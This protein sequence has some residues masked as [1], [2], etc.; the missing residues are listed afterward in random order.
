MKEIENQKCLHINRLNSRST[1]IPA[2]KESVYYYNKQESKNI[3]MLNG[4]YDFTYDGTPSGKIDVPSM[5]QYKGFGKHRYTNVYYPFPLMPPYVGNYN[6]IGEYERTFVIDDITKKYILHFDGVDNAFYVY[7]NDKMAGFSKG[8]HCAS[9]FDVTDL[10]LRGENTLKVVVYTFSDASYLEC[11][12]MIWANG[13]FRDVYLICTEEISIW[14]YRIIR[15]CEDVSVKVEVLGDDISSSEIRVRIDGQE[16]VRKANDENEFLFK[17]NNAQL[18]NAEEPNLYDLTIELLVN[19]EVTEIHSKKIGLCE[20]AI[21][22]KNGMFLVN[23]TPVRFK[24]VNRHEYTPDNGRAVTYEQTKRELQLLKNN[25]FNAIR[26]SHYINNPYFYELCSELG[27]YVIDEADLESHGMWILGDQG[28]LSK[29]PE[30]L[31]AYFDRNERMY[32]RNKN[33]TCIMVWSIGNESGNGP[34]IE[35][36]IEYLRKCEVKK[37]VLY[38]QEGDKIPNLIDFC[39]C[40]YVPMWAVE[41]MNYWQR[42]GKEWKGKGFPVQF[43]EYAHCM[44]NSP[45]ILYNYWKYIYEHPTFNGGFIWEFKNHGIKIGDSYYYGGD[46]DDEPHAL[47]FCMDGLLLSDSTPK[48]G[49]YEAAEAMSPVWVDKDDDGIYIINTNDFKDLSYL[50][51][52]WEIQ[53]DYDI[54]QKGELKIDLKPRNRFNFEVP[55]YPQKAGCRYYLNVNSYDGDKKIGSKQ[56]ELAKVNKKKKVYYAIPFNYEIKENAIVSD[57]FKI[58]FTN[59]MISYYEADGKVLIKERI[60]PNF[61][62]KPTDNDGIKGKHAR[63]T[64]QWDNALLKR[65]DFHAVIS[66]VKTLADEVIFEYKGRMCPEGKYC[67]FD[68]TVRY[69][70]FADATVICEIVGQPYGDLPESLPRIGLSIPMDKKFFEV[71]WFGRGDRENYHDRKHSTHMGL[72][73]NSVE[74]MSFHYDRPQENGNRCDNRF[75]NLT[76]QNNGLTVFGVDT[77]DFSIHDYS[78][79]DLLKAEHKGELKKADKNYLYIDYKTRGLG[80]ASCGWEP[81]REHE[82]YSH[83]FRFVFGITPYESI[84]KANELIHSEFEVKTEVLSDEYKYI[85]G[86]VEKQRFD[87]AD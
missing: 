80:N 65:F 85:P 11:Q 22:F 2:D 73:K 63:M 8:S 70:V 13:I 84:D 56:I 45:G 38:A 39:Q 60:T 74:A 27:F 25:N 23:N 5:W 59:G 33:E 32:E 83:K 46:F 18:W 66:S 26:C 67:G 61:Y 7:I 9:E 82:L 64:S 43:T 71:E 47:N 58:E 76:D 69:R 72:Y 4:E 77:F 12:D 29:D 14:D 42:W 1:V 15:T 31:D 79:N 50:R 3:I 40:G 16:Q 30:W 62:R 35:A 21:D 37:P 6:P 78:I 86:T 41:E 28:Y 44:G 49:F 57:K 53:E 34:N 52:E 48:P 55:E 75:M 54:I 51:I 20:S 87:S 19:G 17:I 81:E 36:C 24:G 10:L 68:T